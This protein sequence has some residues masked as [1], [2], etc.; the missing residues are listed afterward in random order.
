[1]ALLPL[2]LV[3]WLIVLPLTA[4]AWAL[5]CSRILDRR[6]VRAERRASPEPLLST[7]LGELGAGLPS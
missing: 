5:A 2:I 1:M 6:A 4:L 7:S 3:V